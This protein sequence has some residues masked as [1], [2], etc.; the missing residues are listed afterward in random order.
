MGD[1][2]AIEWT[3]ATWNPVSGCTKVSQ[4]CKHCYA[5]RTW[6]RLSAPGQPYDGRD[7]TDVTTHP[8]RLDQPIRWRRPRRI[9]VNSMSDLFHEALPEEFIDQVFAV[10][11]LAPHHVFQVLTKRPERMRQYLA[12]RIPGRAYNSD[13]VNAVYGRMSGS[14][15]R[16]RSSGGWGLTEKFVAQRMDRLFNGEW[17][18]P[19]VWLGVSVEDQDTADGRIPPLLGTPAAVRFLSVEPLLGP[20][21]LERGGWSLLRPRRAPPRDGYRPERIHWVIA[22]GESGP[23]ARPMHPRWVTSLRD[24][25]VRAGIPFHFKQWGEWAAKGRLRDCVPLPVDDDRTL[26][27]NVDGN[28]RGQASG[29]I[30]NR[31]AEFSDGSHCEVMHRVGKKAA[32][33]ELEG[34][35]WDQFPEVSS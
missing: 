1:K 34:Q 11:A 16:S 3:D 21:D 19:N 29:S 5:E 6:K 13:R 22:G 24:Q 4:G 33:R 15:S 2:S 18:L 7:F 27:L 14:G 8:D 28:R 30:T 9:F 17:P 10:M 32:G 26:I 23:G 20:V 31:L 35:L 12:E 25:C